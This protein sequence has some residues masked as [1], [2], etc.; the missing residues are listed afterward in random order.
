[1]VSL[2]MRGSLVDHYSS[3][4]R[5]SLDSG[6]VNRSAGRPDTQHSLYLRPVRTFARPITKDFTSTH[7]LPIKEEPIERNEVTENTIRL[8]QADTKAVGHVLLGKKQTLRSRIETD[9]I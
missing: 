7:N 3:Y 2:P 4:D 9:L 6:S 5:D 8:N 1:M